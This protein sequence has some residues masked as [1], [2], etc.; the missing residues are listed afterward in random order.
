VVL[1]G[2][3]AVG[4]ILAPVASPHDP[5]ATNAAHALEAPSVDFPLGT[6][7]LGQ[8]IASRV[9]FGARV[10]LI[11][12]LGAV[13]LACLLGVPL[14]AVAG[15]VGGRLDAVLMRLVDMLMALPSIVLALTITA[16]LGR[17]IVNVII[18]VGIAESPRFARQMRAA[19]LELKAR[20]FV[21]ASRALGAGPVRVLLTHVLPGALPPLIVIATLGLGTAVLD[22]AGL[23]FLGLGAEPGTPEWGTMLSD[24]VDY[25]RDYVW[26][27]LYPG[28]AIALTVLGFNLLGDG[29]REALDPRLG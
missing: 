21:L 7:A 15:Y 11:I 18:A 14:G 26:I 27:C 4:A 28:L 6:D 3:L 17:G 10:S 22:A 29:V 12:A 20:D 16:M 24:N 25:L 19:V 5:H 2:S 23:G 1:V 8:D 9:L 13:G